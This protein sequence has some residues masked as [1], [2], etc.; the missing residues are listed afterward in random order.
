MPVGSARPPVAC[1]PTLGLAQKET[2]HQ[3]RFNIKIA[4]VPNNNNEKIYYYETIEGVDDLKGSGVEHWRDH[5]DH[6]HVRF[7]EPG[8]EPPDS[9][10]LCPLTCKHEGE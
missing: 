9:C 10:E 5:D 6:F 3:P 1:G 4:T 2:I 7:K 8:G